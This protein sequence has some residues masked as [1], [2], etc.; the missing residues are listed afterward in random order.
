MSDFT[1]KAIQWREQLAEIMPSDKNWWDFDVI[2]GFKVIKAG[3]ALI[4]LAPDEMIV[5]FVEK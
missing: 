5:G 3:T 1:F 2:E 4:L